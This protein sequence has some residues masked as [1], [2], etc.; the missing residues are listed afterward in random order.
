MSFSRI[1]PFPT[2]TNLSD[3]AAAP[4]SLADVNTCAETGLKMAYLISG[5]YAPG[6]RDRRSYVVTRSAAV[7][8]AVAA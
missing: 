4:S 7:A 1:S 8:A 2:E 6:L 3:E 5:S